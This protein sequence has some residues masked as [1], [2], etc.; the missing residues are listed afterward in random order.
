MTALL[1]WRGPA[2]AW[3]VKARQKRPLAR[4]DFVELQV[5][6]DSLELTREFVHMLSVT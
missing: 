5:A 6:G 2:V 4:N 3:T 1:I